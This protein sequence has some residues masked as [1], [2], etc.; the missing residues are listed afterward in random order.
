MAEHRSSRRAFLA[1]VTLPLVAAAGLVRFLTPKRV[2]DSQR[3][4]VRVDDVPLDGALVLPEE[5]VAVTRT[6]AGQ[7]DVL[8]LTC[9]HL[10][11]RVTAT[12]SG[13]AC[14]CHGSCF[15]RH[16]RVTRGPAEQP[17]RRIAWARESNLL[18]LAL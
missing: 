18:R 2:P 3:V 9:T 4:T 11:C 5:G 6:A 1:Q 16:G 10:G 8:S 13:F 15:D 14:P 12:E 17:L 7:V